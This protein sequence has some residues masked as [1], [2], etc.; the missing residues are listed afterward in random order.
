V[1]RSLAKFITLI[2]N[3][4][5]YVGKPAIAGYVLQIEN[6]QLKIINSQ[7]LTTKNKTILFP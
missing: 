1:L 6:N 3:S 5:C 7:Q 4:F 2:I